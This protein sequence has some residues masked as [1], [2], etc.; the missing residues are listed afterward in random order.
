MMGL[1]DGENFLM[2]CLLVLTQF[3]TV[4]D[5]QTD[6]QTHRWTPQTPHDGIGRTYA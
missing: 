5:T 6:R 1:P 3:T 4:T 2:I